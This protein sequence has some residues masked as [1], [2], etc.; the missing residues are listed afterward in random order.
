M[1]ASPPSGVNRFYLV[2]GAAALAGLAAL[3]YQVRKPRSVSI[4]ADVTVLAADTAGFRGYLL[5]ADSAKVE[6]SEYADFQCP[7]C[8]N[9][10]TVQ[11]PTIRDRL[12]ATGL[13]RWRYRDFPLAQHQ[14]S[15]LASHAA[16]CAADQ[17]K[18]WEM[19]AVLYNRQGE[20]AESRNAA[21]RFRDYA[22]ELGVDRSQFDACMSSAKY[23]GRIQASVEE[24]TRIGV[25]STPTFL[26][27]GRLYAGAI[28]S[29]SLLALL[30]P[31]LKQP[32]P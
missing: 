24:G 18:Y 2:L 15:R 8:Q 3:F 23:A 14:N 1:A 31:L 30:R 20:W 28:G 22:T 7:A 16:A 5:G 17:G 29:D 25:S 27:G 19:H 10:E 4:P 32:A 12:I 21:A 26:I 11:F 9:F 6:V 13:V